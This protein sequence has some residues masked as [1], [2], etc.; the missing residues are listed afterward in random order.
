MVDDAEVIDD[1]RSK[2][3]LPPTDVATDERIDA[4]SE[5][6][7]KRAYCPRELMDPFELTPIDLELRMSRFR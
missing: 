6:W 7:E 5:I 1:V 4:G 2:S 3:D